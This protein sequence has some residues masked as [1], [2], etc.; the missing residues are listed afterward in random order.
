MVA[1]A[2]G[3]L[4]EPPDGNL[5]FKMHVLF[6][7]GGVGGSKELKKLFSCKNVSPLKGFLEEF[8][9]LTDFVN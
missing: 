1:H 3:L 7:N 9:V 6:F 8:M 5:Y 4:C 2:L